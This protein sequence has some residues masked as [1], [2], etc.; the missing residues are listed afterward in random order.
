MPSYTLAELGFAG[1]E[2]D[3]AADTH[4][5]A[6]TAGRVRRFALTNAD[7]LRVELLALG[8]TV[9]SVCLATPDAADVS[10]TRGLSE[11]GQ[12]ADSRTYMGAVCGRYAGRIAR[13]S[14]S[15]NGT[16]FALTAND[17]AHHLHG[18]GRGFSARVW[19][20][21]PFGPEL[22]SASALPGADPTPVV[23]VHFD[24]LSPAGEEGY[25]G[26]LHSRVS[27]SLDAESRL[28]ID[29]RAVVEGHATPVNLTNHCYWNLSD[30]PLVHDH[31]LEVPAAQVL[32]FDDS[33]LPS[34]RRLPVAGTALDFTRPTPIGEQLSKLPRGSAGFDHCFVQAEST[35]RSAARSVS[36]PESVGL[37]MVACLSDPASGRSLK[38]YSDQP[39]LVLYTGNFLDGGPGSGG[40][41]QHAALCLE[42]QQFPDAPNQPEFPD[43]VIQP[44]ETYRQTTLYSF[45][46]N[47]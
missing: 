7:G 1:A 26:E 43:T 22:T 40:H 8:A 23:G 31:V 21:T 18:G 17:G 10:L 6:D 25:P 35:E 9:Q 11:P 32:E 41:G 27:Y 20:A 24:Y 3:L 46:W 36:A 39:A 37:P 30:S 5:P 2:F 34:G 12:Y 44:G 29:Y 45:A 42:C 38:V 4:A 28:R 16:A 15:L 14:F 33:L 19:T 13:A 47:R